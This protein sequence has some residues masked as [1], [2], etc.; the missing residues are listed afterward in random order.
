MDSNKTRGLLDWNLEVLLKTIPSK[1]LSFSRLRI[2]GRKPIIISLWAFENPIWEFWF[3]HITASSVGRLGS[4]VSS[5][6]ICHC[7]DTD[8]ASQAKRKSGI[9]VGLPQASWNMEGIRESNWKKPR[10]I[11]KGRKLVEFKLLAS[12]SS[13]VSGNK[14]L[15]GINMNAKEIKDSREL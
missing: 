12:G 1:N 11:R 3:I 8:L 6:L 7:W 10:D 14:G 9:E 5:L 2:S 4:G 15:R 13:H